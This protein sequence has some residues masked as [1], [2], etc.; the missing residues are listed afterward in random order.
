MTKLLCDL[1]DA[2]SDTCCGSPPEPLAAPTEVVNAPGLAA[3]AYRVGTFSTFRRAMLD[4]VPAANLLDPPPN[5]FAQWLEGTPGDYQTMFIELWAYLAD[6][7]TFYQERIAN[8]AYIP[9]ATQL[10]SLIR[11]AQ[12]IGYRP[13]P[14]SAANA[15]AA[16]IVE[17]GK[18]AVV[19]ASFR[20]G[21]R[22][23]AGKPAVIFETVAPTTAVGA[24]SKIPIAVTAPRNQFAALAGY[25][26]LTAPRMTNL[27]P[28]FNDLFGDL[29]ALLL[30]AFLARGIAPSFPSTRRTVVFAGAK[31]RVSVGD[32]LLFV[33]KENDTTAEQPIPRRVISVAVDDKQKTTTVVWEE[34]DAIGIASGDTD[35]KVCAFRVVATPFGSSAPA[36]DPFASPAQE[37]RPWDIA[38]NP[39]H[40]VP[41]PD[42]T[43]KMSLDAVYD[44]IDATPD[45]PGWVL[46]HKDGDLTPV[47]FRITEAKT[48]GRAQYEI[49]AK[50]TRLTFQTPPTMADGYPLRGTT[51]YAAN[52][53]L[54]LQ[55]KLPLPEPIGGATLILDGVFSQLRAGQTVIFEGFLWNEGTNAV[56][57]QR[58]AEQAVLAEPPKI[59]VGNAITTIRITPGLRGQYGVAGA[60]VYANVVGVTQGETVRNEVL[61]SGDGSAFQAFSLKKD[62]L[63]YLP[64]TAAEGLSAV[65]S[66]L[67]VTVNNVLWHE[68]PTLLESGP[69]S[70]QYV[71]A[72]DSAGITSVSFG[73]GVHGQRLP[74]GRDNVKATYRKGI[75][76]S[77][78]VA[79]GAVQVLLDNVVGLQKVTNPLGAIGGTD[80]E[81]VAQIR[82]NAPRSVRTF[83]RAVSVDDY[84][85]LALTYPG[86]AKANSSLVTL[87]AS[88]VALAHPYIQLTVSTTDGVPLATQSGFAGALRAYLDRRR[89]PNVRL[90]IVDFTRVFVDLEATI[91]VLADFPRQGTLD[92]AT[93]AMSPTHGFFAFE[94]LSF[95]ESL[96]LSAV[97]A[98][99]QA[100]PGV[101]S[102]TVITFRNVT[103]PA[104]TI[105]DDIFIRATELAVMKNDPTDTGNDFG[106]LVLGLGEGGFA[107]R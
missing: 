43:P 74:T 5:P 42:E 37:T 52:E 97:Y 26:I 93:A 28:A 30:P 40:F 2:P 64:S 63:T 73:D 75:G 12:L 47:P 33:H 21:T 57:A 91:D 4:R 95:G 46:L 76:A 82:A 3:I 19:P 85:A 61:G 105:S 20:V 54:V 69:Q 9:T 89:D 51:V 86:V 77:G 14:G 59:D 103:D 53:A 99:L 67:G 17:K 65:E 104:G 8:E 24:S 92:A 88:H 80:L 66:T 11:L 79:A 72:E 98:A 50:V 13:K 18:S 38:T 106:R 100:V 60:V 87:D 55:P 83:S 62:P 41:H 96:R 58:Q 29:G 101:R 70:R 6:I 25:E 84:A 81:T 48:A 107:D 94:R 27:S 31:N 45:A 22:A 78:N 1:P 35:V 39:V 10:S 32:W 56:T 23:A 90:R 16:L 102:A 71:T 34:T 68:R 44:A 15:L 49:S 36:G 7:L